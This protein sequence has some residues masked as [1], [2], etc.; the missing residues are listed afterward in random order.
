MGLSFEALYSK[1][2]FSPEESLF[3]FWVVGWFGL[4]GGGVCQITRPPPPP[5]SVDK[6]IPTPKCQMQNAGEQEHR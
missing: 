2:H 6:H 3:A 4:A 5:P 1:F